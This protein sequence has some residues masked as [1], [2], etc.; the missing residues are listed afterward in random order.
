[1]F[2]NI[3]I[4]RI[5]MKTFKSLFRFNPEKAFRVGVERE[6][7]LL[8][9]S[10][11]IVP[12]AQLVLDRLDDPRFGYE[13]SACQL[14]ERIGPCDVHSVERLFLENDAVLAQILEPLGIR[15][16]F[17]EVGPED[18]PLE[19]YPD[20]TGRYAELARNMPRKRLLA[21][22]RVIGIHV[23]V[24]MPDHGTALRVYNRV[25][26]RMGSLLEVGSGSFGER[27]SIYR[28]VAPNCDPE[29]YG[30]WEYFHR[31][32]VRE[33][34]AHDPRR[35]WSLIRISA[36]GTIEFRVFGSTDCPKR[37]ARWARLCHR[38]CTEALLPDRL[39][40]LAAHTW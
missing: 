8:D 7:F 31:V 4:Q 35:C 15:R 20:P 6:C 26:S 32:A 13:L 30:S 38:M 18:M 33:G 22:C 34:F 3:H 29:P 12:L 40:L 23:H 39:P 36:H 9:S 27:L 37:I 11:Q 10:G 16:G 14:E 24:G 1:M 17:G 19:V 25:I 28:E 21:A 2:I 5:A